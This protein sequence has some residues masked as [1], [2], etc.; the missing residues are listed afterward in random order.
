MYR[1]S[2]TFGSNDSKFNEFRPNDREQPL[3]TVSQI[4]WNDYTNDVAFFTA[5]WDGIVRYYTLASGHN[6]SVE[7]RHSWQF[8]F[9]H[10][11]LCIDNT[12]SNLLFA[13]LATGDIGVVKM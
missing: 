13:G 7:V 12:P 5:S 8:F 3:D 4:I 11:V 2:S 9:Q 10:P 1:Y 6:N